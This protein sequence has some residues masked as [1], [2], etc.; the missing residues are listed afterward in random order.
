[1]LRI[2]I[3]FL[4][5][6]AV[7]VSLTGCYSSPEKRA[8]RAVGYISNKLDLND[9]QED[10]LTGIKDKFMAAR[11]E[12]RSERKNHHQM[13]TNLVRSDEMSADEL[14]SMYEDHK[15]SI[16]QQLPLFVDDIIA[17][18]KT[19]NTEQKETIIKFMDKRFDKMEHAAITPVEETQVKIN[20][21]AGLHGSYTNI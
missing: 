15:Q 8:E 2:A 5:S 9:Q 16:E 11:Q 7:L 18:H 20:D 4:A 21:I 6:V 1:M 17:F 10:M 3:G 14:M 13:L 12:M 19:L